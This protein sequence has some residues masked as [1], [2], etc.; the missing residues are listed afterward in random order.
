M[1]KP[2]NPPAS[3]R[4]ISLIYCDSKLLEPIFFL[5][6]TPFFIA[7]KQVSSFL[8]QLFYLSEFISKGFNKTK[9]LQTSTISS[10]LYPPTSSIHSSLLSNWRRTVSFKFFD[11]QV[12]SVPIE[13]LVLLVTFAASSLVFAA[14]DAASVKLLPLQKWEK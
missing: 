13:K 3:F 12:P 11:T 2:L 7:A 4:P 14:V 6:S 9:P 1:G 10:G 8:F 5:E